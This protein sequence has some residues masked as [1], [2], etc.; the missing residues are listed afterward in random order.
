[1]S[2]AGSETLSPVKGFTSGAVRSTR[3]VSGVG[4]GG[5]GGTVGVGETGGT[6]GLSV[7]LM[8]ARAVG[9]AGKAVGEAGLLLQAVKSAKIDN[10][11]AARID[12]RDGAFMFILHGIGR[13]VA[14]IA[15]VECL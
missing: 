14:I 13:V 6:V 1:M 2:T 5:A 11:S 4:V 9:R 10:S 15:Y 12:R 3:R 7:G 8:I